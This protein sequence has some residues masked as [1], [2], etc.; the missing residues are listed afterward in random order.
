MPL[1]RPTPSHL[2]PNAPRASQCRDDNVADCSR[3]CQI[4]PKAVEYRH[5]RLRRLCPSNGAEQ[6]NV[7]R[8]VPACLAPYSAAYRRH[9]RHARFE[10][11]FQPIRSRAA[12]GTPA[13]HRSRARASQSWSASLKLTANL[14]FQRATVSS[15][16]ARVRQNSGNLTPRHPVTA[17]P[18]RGVRASA[19]CKRPDQRHGF[20]HRRAPS[21]AYAPQILERVGSR[22]E[23]GDLR[24]VN[25]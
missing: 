15:Q 17:A 4:I 25:A 11:N 6:G 14:R 16:N 5:F 10:G 8:F 18:I 12:A 19:S 23:P 7:Q 13:F 3:I 9:N 24:I 20:G 2:R 21:E 1:Q 22:D